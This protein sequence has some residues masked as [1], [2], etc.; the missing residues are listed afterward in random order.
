MKTKKSI[1]LF[2]WMIPLVIYSQ[3]AIVEGTIKNING[4]PLEEVS[5][6]Y[7]TTGTIS[8]KNGFYSIKIKAD[9][10]IILLFSH[11]SYHPFSK[12][13]T[14]PKGRTYRFSPQLQLKTEAIKEVTIRNNKRASQGMTPITIEKVKKIPGAN[15]GIENILKTLPGVNSSNE[16]STQYQVRGGNFDENLV[17]VNGIEVYRP[18]LVRS[19]QQEGLSGHSGSQAPGGRRD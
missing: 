3:I 17:Y 18:F 12:K 5:V 11:I 9:E 16:L 7:Q 8:D 13:I 2:L 1:A 6:S 4:E 19:G 15:A 10:E 14:V